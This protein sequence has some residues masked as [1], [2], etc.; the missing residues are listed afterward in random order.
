MEKTKN[1]KK[2][3]RTDE[4]ILAVLSSLTSEGERNA[5]FQGV[6][7]ELDY[8]EK[9]NNRRHRDKLANFDISS[10]ECGFDEDDVKTT[11]PNAVTELCSEMDVEP[12]AFADN[13]ASMSDLVSS[14]ALSRILSRLTDKQQE[15][16]YLRGVHL[17]DNED[18]ADENNV[19]SRNIRKLYERALYHVRGQF[20]P[21]VK[22][23]LKFETDEDYEELV[24]E[25]HIS[26]TLLERE[27][28][29]RFEGEFDD[30][31]E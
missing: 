10:I 31:Y 6:V 17:W 26:T 28:L 18:I 20:L 27:F 30:Y 7:K 25:R 13:A 11:F 2:Q 22:L 8:I 16:L 29:K 3:L 1:K 4:E 5:Y 19:S 21:V 14:P 24:A 15:T 23:R 9:L 12:L